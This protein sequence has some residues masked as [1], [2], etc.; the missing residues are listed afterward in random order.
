MFIKI[1]QS[2]FVIFVSI[3]IRMIIIIVITVAKLRL[4][5]CL[6][7]TSCRCIREVELKFHA[8]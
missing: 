5:L 1:V 8:F 7:V 6:N 4:P 3:V 2:F